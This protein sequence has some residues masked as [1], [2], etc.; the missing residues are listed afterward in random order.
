MLTLKERGTMKHMGWT[1]KAV[2]KKENNGIYIPKYF[3]NTEEF[4]DFTKRAAAY[5]L[6]LI[7]KEEL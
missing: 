4:E 7:S 1:I 2:Y 3:T 6:T 5:N